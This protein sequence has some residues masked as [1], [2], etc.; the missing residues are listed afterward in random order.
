MPPIAG[1]VV[2]EGMN[3]GLVNL[4]GLG[5]GAELMYSFII[6]ICSL[7]IYFGTKEIY[8]LSQYKGIKYFR[9]AFL[10]FALAYFFRSF[11]K[12][13]IIYFN[14]NGLFEVSPMI[15][16]P[17]VSQ[18]TLVVFMYFSSMAIFYF[19][20]SVMWKQ[21][22]SG[23]LIYLFHVIAWII[24][25]YS[26]LSRSSFSY[27]GLNFV[28]FLFILVVVFLS[29]KKSRKKSKGYNLYAVYVLLLFFW[30]LNIIDILL[31]KFLELFQLFIYLISLGIFLLMVY[32][33]LKKAG[34]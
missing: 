29:Y 7:M 15:L 31:P 30:I 17:V 21:W 5:F 9:M 20:Y 1:R 19:L 22:E 32:K 23:K 13:I 3:R 12:F 18:L 33:V 34:S 24:A 4:I 2:F 14:V 10:F 8:E 25:I 11:I 16:N 26:V 27:I 6:I 28:L